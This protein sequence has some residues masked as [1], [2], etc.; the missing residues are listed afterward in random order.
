MCQGFC[1]ENLLALA[2][3]KGLNVPFCSIDTPT[4]AM[5]LSTIS[6]SMSRSVPHMSVYGERPRPTMSRA[7]IIETSG[8]PVST[9][10][11]RLASRPLSVRLPLS[12]V[13]TMSSEPLSPEYLIS[14]CIGGR[15][16]ARVFSSVDFPTPFRP[17]RQVSLPAASCALRDDARM[18]LPW[19]MVRSEIVNVFI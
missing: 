3:G 1:D 17:T 7:V 13:M 19:P 10:L 5:L 9:T 16:P 4:R 12:G 11:T 14:P 15:K 2:V 8:R 6:R 18:C